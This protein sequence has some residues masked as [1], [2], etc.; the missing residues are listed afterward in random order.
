M[1]IHHSVADLVEEPAPRR[2]AA[3]SDAYERGLAIADGGA[4][5]LVEG[6]PLLVRVRVG[7]EGI[8]YLVELHSP[9]GGL[10][11]SCDCPVGSSGEFCAHCVAA[12]L[13][14]WRLAPKRRD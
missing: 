8:Y 4:A 12:A 9:P 3:T 2:L 14:A 10:A 1:E 13:I 11:W 7:D 5:E 6:G